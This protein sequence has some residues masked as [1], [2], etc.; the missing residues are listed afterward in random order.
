MGGNI[1]EKFSSYL[2]F[3]IDMNGGDWSFIYMQRK[4]SNSYEAESISRYC[5]I[6]KWSISS[7]FLHYYFL[8]TSTFLQ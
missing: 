2:F 1:F 8:T 3:D 6:T 5:L 7:R 4:L